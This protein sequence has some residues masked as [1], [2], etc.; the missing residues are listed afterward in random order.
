MAMSVSISTTSHRIQTM[1]SRRVEP[2]FYFRRHDVR[3]S[4]VVCVCMAAASSSVRFGLFSARSVN[5]KSANI[6][7]WISEIRLNVAA[8]VE[9][10]HDDAASPSLVARMPRGF[11]YV[12]SARPRPDPVRLT[13]NH[14]GVCILY[15]HTFHTRLLQLP[16]TST[17]ETIAIHLYRAGFNATIV[18]I[19]WP[20]SQT[21]TQLF[22]N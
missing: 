22:F 4:S 11:R 1:I 16:V 10:W 6:Q 8:L 19:Y 14:G 20:G 13:R 2:T 7:H 18:A 15:D 12:G 3:R 21:I 5:D 17:F 9:T